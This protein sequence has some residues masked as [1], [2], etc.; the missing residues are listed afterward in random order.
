MHELS[1]LEGMIQGLEEEARVRGFGRVSQIRL[2]VGRLCGAEVEALRFAFDPATQDTLADGAV[3]EIIE[4]PGTGI[5][6]ACGREVEI[7]ARFDL[8]PAC[9]EGFVDVT[10]GTNLRILDIE[11]EG[12]P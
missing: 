10:G 1:L 9:G 7:D 4:I 8:C 12:E 2:E 3:L 5:C 6:R 11:V